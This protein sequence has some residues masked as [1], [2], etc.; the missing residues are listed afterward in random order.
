MSQQGP[1][2]NNAGGDGN[3]MTLS[4]EGGPHTPPVANNFNFSGSTAGGS[5]QNG[6]IHFTTPG[7]P[8]GTSDGQM[9]AVVLTDNVTIH[10]NASNELEVVGGV[11][12]ETITGD[13]GG[14]LSPTAGNW[15][16]IT[17]VAAFNSGATVLFSGA[18]STLTLDVSDVNANTLIGNFA[19]GLNTFLADG[20]SSN[21]SL[22][23]ASAASLGAGSF[24]TLLGSSCAGG[25]KDGVNNSIVG[26]NGL[27]SAILGGCSSNSA[28]GYTVLNNLLTGTF[29]SAMG[30]GAGNAYVGAESSNIVL[31]NDGVIG[32]NNTIRIG[33]QGSSDGQQNRCFVAGIVGVTVS[34]EEFVTID[35]TT[36][37]LGIRTSGGVG[38]TI[39]GDT[40]GPL[41]PTAGN[42][43]ILANATAGST[44]FF[45][46]SIS[47]LSLGVTDSRGNTI[48]GLNAGN[49]GATTSTN[50]TAFGQDALTSSTI[51]L[52]S[53]A[54]GY[55]ALR[56]ENSSSNA[57]FGYLAGTLIGDGSKNCCMGDSS[58]SSNVHAIN[59][60]AI[61]YHSMVA[62]AGS[63]VQGGNTAYGFSSLDQLTTGST[64][65]A[66]GSSA[67][68]SLTTTESN[69][70]II[71]SPGI[72]GDN[73]T[74][75]IGLDGSGTGQQNQCFIAGINGITVANQAPVV[76]NTVTGQ[77]GTGSGSFATKYTNV[78][79][80]A[81]PYTILSTDYYI[82]CD[83]SGGAITLNF[84]NAPTANRQWVVKDRTGNSGTN[85]IT[86]TTPGGVVTFDGSTSYLI[87]TAYQAINM[88]ANSTPTYE[89]F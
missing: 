23:V 19:G 24:N 52:N 33:S 29:N 22:G 45:N 39:T 85:N 42:W 69:N 40:G 15:N 51:G 70:I 43:N 49:L 59:N 76:I 36:G 3:I 74:I 54:F 16:I 53:T 80:A 60:T 18:V 4:G 10:I 28:I 12:A 72:V 67:G 32:D 46:G 55:R 68:T 44:I 35:S 1:L 50:N 11:F 30:Q 26:Y 78:N 61:G 25:L 75:R 27:G 87:N 83:T 41:S 20:G 89:V 47:T 7:G 66:I 56:N 31:S 9:D 86:V 84:P 13:V 34:N 81:S 73:N 71:G 62:Y 65:I 82:S 77:L 21:T 64:N 63:I 2:K 5:G 14:P 6:A 79:F 8:L 37:Q 38:E 48:M 88:L 57:A 17:D 58:L